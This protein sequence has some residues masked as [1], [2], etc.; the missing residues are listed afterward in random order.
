MNQLSVQE[1]RDGWVLLFD[2]KSLDGWRGYKQ[3]DASASRWRAIDG[4]LTVIKADGKDT[5]GA[6]DLITTATYDDFDLTWEWKVAEG[7]N[8]GLK[9]FVQEYMDSAIGHEYQLIDDARH[10]DARI[11]PHRQTAALYDVMPAQNRPTRPAGELNQSRVLVSGKHVEHWLNGT[12]V[13]QYELES[14]E[15]RKAIAASKFKD[16]ARFGTVQ[17]GHILLQDHGDEVWLRNI[18]IR[19]RKTS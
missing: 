19:P 5:H 15:L 14:P 11:G 10:P 18:K 3:K 17:K 9:Y 2:G 6:R 1:K 4:M 8:S 13:L 12:R 7:A 16:V